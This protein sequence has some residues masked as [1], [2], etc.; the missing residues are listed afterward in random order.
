[1]WLYFWPQIWRASSPG[2]TSRCVVARSWNDLPRPKDGL[3]CRYSTLIR[4]LG[5]PWTLDPEPGTGP[6]TRTL[7]LGIG[8]GKMRALHIKLVIDRVQYQGPRLGTLWYLAG[9]VEG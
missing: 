2:I 8:S 7:G 5:R 1:M 9:V 3:N 6:W 4:V